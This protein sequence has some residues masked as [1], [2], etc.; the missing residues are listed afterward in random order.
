[1]AASPTTVASDEDAGPTSIDDPDTATPIAPEGFWRRWF[2]PLTPTRL[3]VLL[4]AVAF[5][6]AGAGYTYRAVEQ[7]G[8]AADVG[9]LRDMTYHHGQ[10]VQM[11]QLAMAADMPD[12]ARMFA[13]EVVMQQRFETGLMRATLYRLGGDPD[14]DGTAMGWMDMPVPVDEMPGMATAEEMSA[15][16]NAT[17]EE[18][19]ELFYALMSRHHLGGVHMAEEAADRAD[20]PWVRDMA[21]RMARNQSQEVLEYS[22]S[23]QRQGLGVPDGYPETPSIVVPPER[24]DSDPLPW[25]TIAAGLGLATVAAIGWWILRRSRTDGVGTDPVEV[26]S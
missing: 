10:A 5:L 11:A 7:K 18:A 24:G 8:S 19:A 26:E 6:G 13:Q 12:E 23:R 2:G 25:L 9:F 3:V 1:M 21:A 20:D 17:G 22:A 16:E 14:G 4:V 15:L